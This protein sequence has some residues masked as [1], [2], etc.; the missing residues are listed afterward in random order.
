MHTPDSD[1]TAVRLWLLAFGTCLALV[2]ALLVWTVLTPPFQGD[3]TRIGRLSETAFGPTVQ[4]TTTDPALRV[5][6]ALDEA[7]V[8]VI[9][10]SFSAPLRWQAV[11]V[12]QGMK[13][14]TVHWETLGPVCA[15]LES[16]LRRQG[17]RGTTVVIESVERALDDRLDRSLACAARQDPHPLQTRHVA[18]DRETAGAFGL[19]TRES[20]FTGLLTTLHT[21]K[22]LHTDAPEVVNRHDGAEQVRIQRLPGGCQ[23]FS[24]HACDRGLFF[25]QDRT[26]PP[27]SPAMVERMQ[28]ISARHPG[29]AITWL[30]VPNKTSVYLEP[31]RATGIGTVLERAGLGP[32]LFSHFVRL[33]RQTRDLYSPND[34]HTSAQGHRAIGQ[35]LL[36]WLD[37]QAHRNP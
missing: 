16:L 1:D 10:D 4:A 33:S 23:R 11:L 19:N 14:A 28:R 32:D 13:V 17:F 31:D 2:A 27:F 21:W 22:A 36:D 7:E 29:L 26:A 9:G 20:L 6:S 25:A 12:A 30:V 24:H 35:R 8:L 18:R 37:T 15:D 5:S 3:L 34:T